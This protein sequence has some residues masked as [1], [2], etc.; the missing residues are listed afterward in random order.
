MKPILGL[1]ALRSLAG[2]HDDLVDCPAP[3]PDVSLTFTM[4]A[5]VSEGDG[6]ALFMGV[7][8]VTSVSDQQ[9][10]FDCGTGGLQTVTINAGPAARLSAFTP[11]LAARI[12]YLEQLV[13][14]GFKE[15]RISS[16][17]PGGGVLFYATQGGDTLPSND[18]APL[19]FTDEASC[20]P[21]DR[22]RGC[23]IETARYSWDAS[24]PGSA[25]V[26]A[27]DGSFVEV[28]EYQLWVPRAIVALEDKGKCPGSFP[29]DYAMAVLYAP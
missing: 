18:F 3:D 22:D 21:V 5:P 26:R 28:G 10:G 14:P 17:K 1:L 11:G 8:T 24:A 27:Y 20:R 13:A 6:G 16:M 15:L 29:G 7:C 25:P 4:S 2:C 12:E 23:G 9:L 19:E